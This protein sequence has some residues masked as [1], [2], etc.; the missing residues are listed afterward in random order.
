[1]NIDIK[2]H[3]LVGRNCNHL[4]AHWIHGPSVHTHIGVLGEYSQVCFFKSLVQTVPI[5]PTLFG[6]QNLLLVDSGLTYHL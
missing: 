3:Q 1:M 5:G 2:F 6:V 4:V